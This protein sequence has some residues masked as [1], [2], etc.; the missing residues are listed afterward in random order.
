MTGFFDWERCAGRFPSHISNA[1]FIGS[2]DSVVSQLYF[3]LLPHNKTKL[4]ISMDCA[5]VV[6]SWKYRKQWYMLQS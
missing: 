2:L 6:G 1:H 5:V 3:V 4:L